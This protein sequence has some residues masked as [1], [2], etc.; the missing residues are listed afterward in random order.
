MKSI[1]KIF[2]IFINDRIEFNKLYDEMQATNDKLEDIN[3]ENVENGK[4]LDAIITRLDELL[5]ILKD[6][7]AGGIGGSDGGFDLNLN[8][9]SLLNL[10]LSIDDIKLSVDALND[11]GLTLKI[12]IESIDSMLK[13]FKEENNENLK[14]L[15][16]ENEKQHE[17][18]ARILNKLESFD[19]TMNAD[20]LARL[21]QSLPSDEL[22]TIM[23][24]KVPFCF[25]Y[26]IGNF[27]TYLFGD[28][29]S[30]ED[31]TVKATEVFSFLRKI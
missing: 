14:K 2:L 15:I 5:Q 25:I 12:D 28:V 9:D 7:D 27:L 29:T 10:D 20:E 17:T 23:K 22:S 24:Q 11:L 1:K 21:L 18:I 19:M 6:A 4:K 16:E 3:K 30:S 13:S 26:D 31:K 8:F